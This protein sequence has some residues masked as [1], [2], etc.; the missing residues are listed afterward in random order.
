[1][2]SFYEILCRRH[3]ARKIAFFY[4]SGKWCAGKSERYILEDCFLS[5]GSHI[6]HWDSL[7]EARASSLQ[8]VEYT[9]HRSQLAKA[10]KVPRRIVANQLSSLLAIP[11]LMLGISLRSL[12]DLRLPL[13]PWTDIKPSRYKRIF[14]RPL[15]FLTSALCLQFIC[16][17]ISFKHFPFCL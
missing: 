12:K 5:S 6:R 10:T 16:L 3:I 7:E 8:I 15:Y 4:K 2:E 11:N 1:M 13:T 14:H 9:Q 17:F